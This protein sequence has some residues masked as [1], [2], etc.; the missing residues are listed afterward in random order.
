M[1]YKPSDQVVQIDDNDDEEENVEIDNEEIDDEE[2]DNVEDD[3]DEEGQEATGGNLPE[4]QSI[5]ESD[6]EKITT[7]VILQAKP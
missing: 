2:V 7:K 6:T 1:L 5:Q 3:A 4:I